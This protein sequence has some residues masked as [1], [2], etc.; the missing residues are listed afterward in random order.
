MH[1]RCGLAWRAC[2]R[3][4]HVPIDVAIR[5]LPRPGAEHVVDDVVEAR[6]EAHRALHALRPPLP[7]VLSQRVPTAARCRA[8]AAVAALGHNFFMAG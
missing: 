5:L 1:W 7:A 2:V 3:P 8:V 4:A 6:A